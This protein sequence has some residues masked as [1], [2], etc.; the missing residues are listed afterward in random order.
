MKKILPILIC[1]AIV[2]GTAAASGHLSLREA[3]HPKA[4][5][6]CRAAVKN[7]K[8]G[9]ARY[10]K[11]VAVTAPEKYGVRS[12]GET[13]QE[14][15]LVSCRRTDPTSTNNYT[16]FYT[17]DEYG[18]PK[19]VEERTGSAMVS[20]SHWYDY[21]YKWVD[22]GKVWGE[23]KVYHD[24]ELTQHLVRWFYSPGAVRR[25]FDEISGEEL[26]FDR[27][28]YMTS[29][30]DADGNGTTWTY[31]APLNEWYQG[32]CEGMRKVEYYVSGSTVQMTR[33]FKYNDTWYI[34]SADIRYF[35]PEGESLGYYSENYNFNGEENVLVNAYGDRH[36]AISD[37]EKITTV[38]ETFDQEAKRWAFFN[39]FETSL[40]WSKTPWRYSPGEVYF[41][42]C[43]NFDTATG[44]WILARSDEYEWVNDRIAKCTYTE[45]GNPEI[46]Y[47]LAGE[48]D[49]EGDNGLENI[50]YD[51]TTGNYAYCDWVEENGH[52]IGYYYSCKADGTVIDKFREL[53]NDSW[54][55]WNGS[56]WVKCTGTIKIADESD[57]YMMLAFDNEGRLVREEEYEYDSGLSQFV[58]AYRSEYTYDSNGGVLEVEYEMDGADMYKCYESYELRNAAGETLEEWNKSYTGTGDVTYGSRRVYNDARAYQNFNWSNGGWESAGWQKDSDYTTYPDGSNMQISYTVDENGVVSKDSKEYNK[59][60]EEERISERYVWDATLNDWVGE[61]KYVWKH[62]VYPGF[63][64]VEARDPEELLDEYFVPKDVNDSPGEGQFSAEYHYIWDAAGKTWKQEG[65]YGYDFNV[66]DPQTLEISRIGEPEQ[67]ITMK[68]D[69][70]RRVTDVTGNSY[71]WEFSEKHWE[72]DSEGRVAGMT[73]AYAYAPESICAYEYT[74]GEVTVAGSGV[75]DLPAAEGLAIEAVYGLDGMEV[76]KEG[77]PAGVY[78]VRYSDGTVRK[79]MVK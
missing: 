50:A 49:Y 25:Q 12:E 17:Y 26:L 32:Y 13:H 37:N 68:V 8:T 64:Y 46:S 69:G 9:N 29:R 72:Y 67:K 52:E 42:R 43:Y 23:K 22:P 77:L 28:G 53:E 58:L 19:Q 45:D 75:E 15:R 38:Y 40:N 5:Q 79:I 60:N 33:W 16:T 78:V 18:F 31:F 55:H 41:E 1:G 21:E 24:K 57:E 6:E 47:Y 76:A 3:G 35:S 48:P 71:E 73:Y 65:G 62:D 7:A 56:A 2:S 20:T 59:D 54:E 4:R 11:L 30:K 61:N 70:S 66:K 51:V 39:K 74:Y 14:T 44:E 36:S 63:E 10:K 27:N 34:E